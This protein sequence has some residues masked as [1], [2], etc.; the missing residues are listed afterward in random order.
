MAAGVRIGKTLYS[1]QDRRALTFQ[2]QAGTLE[3]DAVA[4]K[5]NGI[6]GRGVDGDPFYGLVEV[7]EDD[8]YCGVQRAGLITVPYTGAMSAGDKVLVVDGAGK[9]KI[10]GAPAA[11]DK[12]WSV[13]AWN[14][15]DLKV[16]IDAS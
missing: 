16:V 15:P 10:K 11:G 12:A 14:A 1:G 4:L 7:K 13:I 5:G 3:G 8:G 2:W 9:V 6:V